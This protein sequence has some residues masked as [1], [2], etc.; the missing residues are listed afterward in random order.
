MAMQ[1]SKELMDS[2]VLALLAQEDLYGYVLTKSVQDVFAVSES[3]MYPVLRRIK[4]K[5]WVTTYD[6][7]YEGRN[8]RYYQITDAGRSAL[9]EFQ[10]DWQQFQGKVNA[11][12]TEEA[13]HD[14]G[15]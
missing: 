5:D 4:E 10:T 6:E 13:Q 15:Q 12:L 11:I 9:A 2:I 14:D 7:P 1:L 3:T 8:R